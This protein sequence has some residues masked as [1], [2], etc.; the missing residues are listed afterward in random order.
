MTSPRKA[1][2][3]ERRKWSH[4]LEPLEAARRVMKILLRYYFY[5]ETPDGSVNKCREESNVLRYK[6]WELA[7]IRASILELSR[8]RGEFPRIHR[9]Y[10]EWRKHEAVVHVV[11]RV[12]DHALDL[13]RRQMDSECEMPFVQTMEEV[14]R[15]WRRVRRMKPDLALTT[16]ARRWRVEPPKKG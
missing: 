4:G 10:K 2:L 3:K 15:E 11:V 1:T 7:G 16:R 14:R 13:T 9:W 12:G 5:L 8:P 6:L